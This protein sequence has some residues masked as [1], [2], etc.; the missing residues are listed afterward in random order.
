MPTQHPPSPPGNDIPFDRTFTAATDKVERLT[1]LVRRLVAG[2]AGPFT[3]T[4]TCSYIVGQGAVAII[5]PGPAD[6]THI[7][8]LIAAVRDETVA[9]IVVTHTHRDHSPAAAAIK[10]ATGA[11]ITGCA[12]Y[13]RSGASR[14]DGLDPL[15]AANDQ[16]YVPDRV[17]HDGDRIAGGDYTLTAVATPGHAANHLAFSLPEE[18]ALF[19]GDHVMA[20]STSVVAPPDGSMADYMAS[21]EKLRERSETIYWP[22]HGGPVREPRR[23]V[24]ALIH[25]RRQRE[26]SILARIEAGDRDIP[27]IVARTYEG[28]N[29]ALAGAAGL[30]VLAHIEDLV[31][32]GLV[33][34][35][36]TP[37]L[38]ARYAPA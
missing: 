17:L 18:S 38:S 8:A 26:A 33:T 32:R 6:D 21:L 25:H 20:W 3:F 24:R 12:P 29:P 16:D 1:P 19:S 22:G 14:G 13:R 2:N 31:A 11:E 35:D 37:S 36:R 30:S 23:F 5:D 34:S 4:G 7:A 15:D 27:A 10:A 28:L 9:H